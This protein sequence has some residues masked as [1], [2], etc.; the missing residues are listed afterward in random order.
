MFQLILAPSLQNNYL[1]VSQSYSIFASSLEA[2]NRTRNVFSLL[3]YF[4]YDVRLISHYDA[5]SSCDPS[6]RT[7]PF[8]AN[9]CVCCHSK[10]RVRKSQRLEMCKSPIQF[11]GNFFYLL[12]LFIFTLVCFCY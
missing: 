7:S 3:E 12:Q 4:H 10:T 9:S 1:P 5:A 8:H 6:K 11:V 2:C